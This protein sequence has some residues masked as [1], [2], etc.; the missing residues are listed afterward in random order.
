MVKKEIYTW[1][2]KPQSQT[3]LLN[4]LVKL[5][6]FQKKFFFPTDEEEFER[7]SYEEI[8]P[9]I[10]KLKGTEYLQK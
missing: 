1:H 5:A 9:N 4:K 6:N 7:Y 2:R 8:S 10:G 3:G